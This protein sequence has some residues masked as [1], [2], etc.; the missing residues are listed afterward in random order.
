MTNKKI[1]YKPVDPEIEHLIREH[2]GTREAT[3]EVLKELDAKNNLSPAAINDTA[4][5][6]YIPANQVYGMATFYSMLS[7]EERKKILRVCDGP[8]CWLKRAAVDG[9]QLTVDS[10][11]QTTVNGQPSILEQWLSKVGS[12]WSVERSSCLGLCDRAPAVLVE[13]HQVGP[14]HPIDAKRVCEGWRDIAT[15][16]L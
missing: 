11:G 2:G 6:L 14:A 10:T 8:V 1:V 7:L 3:L 5:A 16:Y 9:G 12:Q 13:D 4:R 15:D